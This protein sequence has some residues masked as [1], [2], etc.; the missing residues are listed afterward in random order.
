MPYLQLDV[1]GHYSIDS[2]RQVA[3]K[4]ALPSA[5]WEKA[6]YGALLTVSRHQRRC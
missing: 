3:K 5:S 4:S 1:N 2:K 6:A